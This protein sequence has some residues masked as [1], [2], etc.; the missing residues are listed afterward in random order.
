MA[1]RSTVASAGTA[2]DWRALLIAAV[3]AED[4]RRRGGITRV[5]ARLGVS[6]PYVSQI[7]NGL[8]PQVPEQ[9]IARV[10]DRLYVVD[11]CP[12]TG[13]PQPRSECRRIG[14]GPAPTHNPLA[15]RIWKHCQA[16]PHH[17]EKQA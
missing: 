10:I 7:I 8:R 15:M 16:C 1:A 3:S 14:M 6:R 4:A 12:A 9:F 13:H 17:P 2:I 11:E 5:A